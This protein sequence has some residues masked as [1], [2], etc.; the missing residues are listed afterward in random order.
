[1]KR[2]AIAD[3]RRAALGAAVHRR[4]ARERRCRSPISRRPGPPAW[5]FACGCPPMT[6][7]GCTTLPGS[8]DAPDRARRR[9]DEGRTPRRGPRPPR[10]S[11]TDRRSRRAR[12]PRDGRRWRSGAVGSLRGPCSHRSRSTTLA[13]SSALAQSVPSTAA[14]PWN[15]QTLVRWWSDGHLEVEPVARASRGGGTSPCRC[16]GST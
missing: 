12:A 3:P 5:R 7:K 13:S 9:A 11:R 6:A 10:R 2:F 16:R 15:F 14:S 1:M 4:R 8:E